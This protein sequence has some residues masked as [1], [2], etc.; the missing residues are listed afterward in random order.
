MSRKKPPSKI[1]P[2]GKEFHIELLNTAQK[3]AWGAFQKHDVLF[4]TGPAGSGKSFLAAAFAVKQ[5]LSKAASKIVLTRPIVE[6]GE[7]LGFL[8]GDFQEKVNPYMMPLYDCMDKLVGKDGM[9]RD[10]ITEATEIAPLAFMR[11]RSQP[12]DASVMTPDGPV[13]MGDLYIGSKVLGRSGHPVTVL[14]IYPQ[15][16]LDVYKITF[17]DGA[18]TE[19]SADHLWDTMTLSEQRRGK[20]FTTKST[21]EIA[22]KLK[23]GHQF[24]HRI[25]MA[26]P[27][28]FQ[29]AS[30]EMDPYAF[31]V[32]V[33]DGN[34]H[35]D[36]SLTFTS[37]DEEIVEHIR[38]KLPGNLEVKLAEKR[39]GFCNTYRISGHTQSP[40]PWR[41]Y[42]ASA[43]LLGKTSNEKFLPPEVQTMPVEDRL[44]VLR[45]LLDA[46]GCCFEQKGK[47]NPRVQF[48][49]T[50][51]Q[52][53]K[54]IVALVR[55]LG[56]VASMRLRPLTEEE[57]HEFRGRAIR[58]NHDVWVVGI[59]MLENPFRL[60]RKADKFVPLRPLRT[61]RS[62]EKV[63]RK[64][65]QCIR[66]DAAD[67]LYLT[68]DFIVTHNTFDEAVCILDEAQNCSMT[69][70]K[71]FLTRFGQGSKVIITGDP[72]QSDLRG[73][74]ALVEVLDRLNGVPGIG[75]V[76]FSA[77]S[78]VRHP[79]IKSIL[80]RL[81]PEEEEVEDDGGP[82]L[83]ES[84]KDYYPPIKE[85]ESRYE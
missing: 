70:L 63:G 61:I 82:S 65:C 31:G 25:P 69:Q 8:P 18:S 81:E 80:E 67:S 27:V 38:A 26:N 66:V 51:E 35:E 22:Q 71:L 47:R 1:A 68:D 72:D 9:L 37:A 43:G 78:I 46:D 14:G 53:A 40:N 24:N 29:G 39:E 76:E 58:H 44:E 41:R 13:N 4:L 16:E 17:T 48:Y 34:F 23:V 85:F 5:L 79:L 11:G 84:W 64:V 57:S 83:K 19:C 2:H 28:Q 49:S 30:I 74:V 45:G 60:S 6:S 7:K 75:M 32:L 3:M 56:G 59:R 21:A 52:L 42:L 15:G 50:S 77:S 36:A 33:G 55:G 20:G 10:R 12:L 54:D 62:V 73:D